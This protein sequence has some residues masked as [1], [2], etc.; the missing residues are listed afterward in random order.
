MQEDAFC[1][2]KSVNVN[3]GDTLSMSVSERAISLL[4]KEKVVSKH[5]EL[6]EIECS[7][8]TDKLS[9][10]KSKVDS[11]QNQTASNV[12][13]TQQ[14]CFSDTVKT[15]NQGPHALY[16]HLM[17]H[18][19]FQ[20]YEKMKEIYTY[21]AMS[22][23]IEANTNYRGC[24]LDNTGILASC[25]DIL[26]GESPVKFLKSDME[27]VLQ[28]FNLYATS[29]ESVPCLNAKFTCIGNMFARFAP[30]NHCYDKSKTKMALNPS[31]L[32][33]AF[34]CAL[35][36][37]FTRLRVVMH[38]KKNGRY[39]DILETGFDMSYC[40]SSCARG[41]G[42]YVSPDGTV[43]Y[44]WHNNDK[45]NYNTASG[46]EWEITTKSTCLLYMDASEKNN[47]IRL[48]DKL[49]SLSSYRVTY[50]ELNAFSIRLIYFDTVIES[51]SGIRFKP[52]SLSD[53]PDGTML[54]GIMFTPD[55]DSQDWPKH[56]ITAYPMSPDWKHV[57]FLN[58][59][60][61]GSKKAYENDTVREKITNSKLI[62][63]LLR[64]S[65]LAKRNNKLSITE[66]EWKSFQ[67]DITPTAIVFVEDCCYTPISD[68]YQTA[69]VLHDQ[70]LFV[71]LGC[72]IAY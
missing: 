64:K 4:E 23:Y 34:S 14:W 16:M 42:L 13:T 54:C 6:Q 45:R 11:L 5:I 63:T 24:R 27:I 71:A 30:Y 18:I 67:I 28:N 15:K 20:Y 19:L 22:K 36:Y 35:Q 62:D 59:S 37:N 7:Q 39:K 12:Q 51:T 25:P 32:R 3:I 69:Y 58:W 53:G 49:Q 38:G 70:R 2:K 55:G 40:L 46:L 10:L 1:I 68:V 50:Q 33:T 31:A 60:Y 48:A 56:I 61:L 52:V 57:S 66:D 43:A 72:L 8:L 41:K 44:Q 21:G 9:T 26:L 29:L 65:K 47:S 17:Q